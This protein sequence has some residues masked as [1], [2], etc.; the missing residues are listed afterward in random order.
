M[1]TRKALSEGNF[2]PKP[3]NEITICTVAEY[4]VL[5]AKRK[6]SINPWL[7]DLFTPMPY[8]LPGGAYT[9]KAGTHCTPGWR[10]GNAGKVPNYPRTRIT[11]RVLI[12]VG[13]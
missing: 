13:G 9:A 11:A 4:S 12:L 8:Q 7:L 10:E 1:F 5:A 3:Y 6:R 2:H